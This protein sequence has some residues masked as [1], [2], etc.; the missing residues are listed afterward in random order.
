LSQLDAC[1]VRISLDDFGT[2]Q[3][4]LAYLLSLP[5]DELKI[6]R[7]FVS[8]ML[9]DS[10]H[11]T[12]VRSMI[13]LGHNVGLEVVAEGVETADVLQTL[14]ELGCDVA[15]GYFI[16]RPMPAAD[17]ARFL[18][19]ATFEVGAPEARTSL[20]PVSRSEARR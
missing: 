18:A 16:A 19:A 1:G 15:Q 9:E 4:S 14:G 17:L 2:G 8:R 11:A 13:E 6:D 10:D 20:V 7:M 3:T 12:I 5:L